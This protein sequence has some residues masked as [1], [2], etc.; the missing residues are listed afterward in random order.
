[1]PVGVWI[2][3]GVGAVATTTAIV[4]GLQTLA[5]QRRFNDAP[6]VAER[7]AFRTNQ[8]VTNTA[9]AVAGASVAI[10]IVLFTVRGRPQRVAISP[11]EAVWTSTW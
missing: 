8:A 10:G 5:A 9:W 6:S 4:F 11:Q 2:A 7:N 3:G 1:V